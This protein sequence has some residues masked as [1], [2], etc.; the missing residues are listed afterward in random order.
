MLRDDT[1]LI[2]TPRSAPGDASSLSA[3]ARDVHT[4]LA[5][6]GASFLNDIAE[7]V[8]RMT[9][10]VEEALWELV[11]AGLVTGDGVAG[12]RRLLRI[13]AR[14]LHAVPSFRPRWRGLAETKRAAGRP[15]PVGRWTLW[16]NDAPDIDPLQRAEAFAG[17]MLRRYG[18]V[19]RELLAR[20]RRAPSWRT[21]VDIFRRWEAR[22]EIRGGRFVS[23]FIGEQ[24]ALPEAVEALRAVRRSPKDEHAVIVSAADPTNLVGIVTPGSRV[25]QSSNLSI[26]YRDG[27]P[28]GVA[29]LGEL[30]S[31]LR[32]SGDLPLTDALPL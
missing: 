1:P 27:V 29:P 25:P 8:G 7:G 18:V 15:L 28:L 26:A 24:F 20:E 14:S 23:G 3:A 32:A 10:R 22:Q 11:S 12:L 2:A 13:N 31:R 17:L 4:F 6:R 30:R 16:R 19:F 5:D 9:Y 21:L